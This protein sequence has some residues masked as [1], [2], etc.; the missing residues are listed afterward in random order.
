[1]KIRIMKSSIK[2]IIK[3]IG[4]N[5]LFFSLISC[6]YLETSE[7]VNLKDEIFPKGKLAPSEYFTGNAWVTGLVDNDTVFTTAAGNVFFEAGARSNWHLHPAG[8]ILLVTSG[9]GYHQIKG[10][11]IEIIRK[12]DVIKCPPNDYHWHGASRDST[13]THIYIVPN[14]E[15]GIVEWGEPVS[16]VEYLSFN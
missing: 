8:Q 2:K 10:Q 11:P 13:M 9:V 15:K 7:K 1:M 12:G 14:T 5:V 16:E 6:S 4:F 3:G